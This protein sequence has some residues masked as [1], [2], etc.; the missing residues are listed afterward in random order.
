VKDINLFLF[1]GGTGLELIKQALSRG[2]EVTAVVRNPSKLQELLTANP[3]LKV[4][5][6]MAFK[7]LIE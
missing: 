7:A 3:K 5:F 2:H 6:Y 4:Y 1:K